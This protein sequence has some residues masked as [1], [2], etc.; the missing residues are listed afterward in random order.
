MKVTNTVYTC[1]TCLRKQH[2][3]QYGSLP[4]HWVEISVEMG[5]SFSTERLNFCPAC[6]KG[7]KL[8][9]KKEIPLTIR[10]FFGWGPKEPEAELEKRGEG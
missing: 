6:W 1:D 10:K 9:T 8:P 4:P 7:A 3:E 2:I 5:H